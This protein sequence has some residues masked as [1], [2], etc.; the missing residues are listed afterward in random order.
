MFQLPIERFMYFYQLVIE[1]NWQI[2]QLLIET[3]PDII[4]IFIHYI[5]LIYIHRNY[6]LSEI[7]CKFAV[8]FKWAD[9]L[10]Y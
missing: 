3:L 2:F 4:S 10:L 6:P 1:R 9:T 8:N 5:I 7:Y